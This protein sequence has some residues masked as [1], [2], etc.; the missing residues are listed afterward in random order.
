[1]LVNSDTADLQVYATF[2]SCY[3]SHSHLPQSHAINAHSHFASEHGTGFCFQWGLL[4]PF[5]ATPLANAKK[6]WWTCVSCLGIYIPQVFLLRVFN[7]LTH[8]KIMLKGEIPIHNTQ[9]WKSRHSGSFSSQTFGS[10]TERTGEG[11]EICYT[12]KNLLTQPKGRD[13]FLVLWSRSL[14]GKTR[15]RQMDQTDAEQ[16]QT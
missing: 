16:A 2:L 3:L 10:D 15:P 11:K 1:M 6:W 12:I 8:I 14:M 9:L 4:S 7:H 5:L 13:I